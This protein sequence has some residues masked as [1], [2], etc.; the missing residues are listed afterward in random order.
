[1]KCPFCNNLE[2]QVKDSRPTEDD[3]AIRR[4]RLC[5]NC[6][7]RFTSFERVQLRDLTVIKKDGKRTPFNRDKLANSIIIALRKRKVDADRIEKLIS[8]IVRRLESSGEVDIPSQMI[9]KLVMESLSEIDQV[10]YVRFA[11]VYK[12]FREA[13]DFEDFLGELKD[14]SKQ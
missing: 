9:G 14:N 13:K 12:N 2:T 5:P 4:R 3:S 11:S 6:G 7:S 8:G 1:M 10:A